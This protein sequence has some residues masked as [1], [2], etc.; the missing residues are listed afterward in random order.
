M[1]KNMGNKD[2]LIRMSLAVII[3]LLYYMDVIGGTIAIVLGIVA[4]IFVVTSLVNFCP[5]YALIGVNTC[6]IKK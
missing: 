1:T 4:V 5:L 2:K 3:A 6:E